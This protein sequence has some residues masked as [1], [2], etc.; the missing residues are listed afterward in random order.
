M[1]DGIEWAMFKNRLFSEMYITKCYKDR[2]HTRFSGL[3]TFKQHLC[4]E[5]LGAMKRLWQEALKC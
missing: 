5:T 2:R 4:P 1:M 3:M